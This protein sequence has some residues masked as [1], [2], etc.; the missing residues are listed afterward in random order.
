MAEKK[1]E[2]F[3]Q[4]ALDRLHSPDEL[5]KLYSHKDAVGGFTTG[6]YWSSSEYT[7]NFAWIIYFYNGG[8][9]YDSK[10]TAYYV[11]AIRYF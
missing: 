5:D 8:N 10:S 6:Y 9:T 3:Q 11:R 7:E 1:R 4:K 2:L